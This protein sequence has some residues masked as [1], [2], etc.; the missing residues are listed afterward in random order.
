MRASEPNIRVEVETTYIAE[1]SDPQN[2]QYVFAYTISL[3]NR[4]ET[5][6]Q[7]LRR[8]WHITDGNG[9]Q[10]QIEGDGVVGEQP[11]LRPGEMF[12]YTSGTVLATPMGMMEGIYFWIDQKEDGF[13]VPIP[14][15]SLA[16]PQALH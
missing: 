12:Q 9:K 1:Q 15:F 6:A 16:I 3:Q 4:G 5:A 10:E 13:E 11:R 14:P 7:L 8:R 2:D